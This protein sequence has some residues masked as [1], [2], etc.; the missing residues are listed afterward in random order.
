MGTGAGTR[1]G[2]VRG[3]INVSKKSVGEF[4][5]PRRH[6]YNDGR[7]PPKVQ[8]AP[9]TVVGPS[10]ECSN[11]RSRL[12]SPSILHSRLAR[13]GGG[14]GNHYPPTTFLLSSIHTGQKER[15][16]EAGNRLVSIKSSPHHPHIQNGNCVSNF[17]FHLGDSLGLLYR[18]RRRI[19]SRA[20]IL[21]VP[22]ISRLPSKGKNL[23]L[24]VSSL[25]SGFGSVGVFPGHKTHQTAFARSPDSHIQLP[26][27]FCN[28]RTLTRGAPC[29]HGCG[30]GFT[31]ASGVQDKLGEVQSG[32]FPADRISGSLLGLKK[33]RI[34]HSPRQT[35]INQDALSGDVSEKLDDQEGARESDGAD[36]LRI[37]LHYPG[38]ASSPPRDDVDEPPL[39]PLHQ[40]RLYSSGWGSQEVA[41]DLDGPV[42][43]ESARSDACSSAVTHLDDRRII[44]GLVWNP[45]TTEG[46]GG[47]AGECV[48]LFHEL[49]GA[50]GDPAGSC[51]ISVPPSGQDGPTVVRQ[52]NGSGL[53][54]PSG[55]GE[56]SAPTLPDVGDTDF[57]QGRINHLTSRTPTGSPECPSGPRVA[58]SSD[59]Y[60]MV[61]RQADVRMD[62]QSG[63]SVRSGP[64][65]NEGKRPSGS[66]CFSLPGQLGSG[67]QR[68]Q[69]RLEPLGMHLPD[70]PNK[71]PS[72]GCTVSTGLS[73]NRD[74]RGSVMAIEGVVSPS[75]RSLQGVSPSPPAELPITPDDGERLG[76]SRQPL[77]LETSRLAALRAPWI[78]EGLSADSVEIVTNAHKASTRRNYQATWSKFLD[79]LRS[80]NIPHSEV[81]VYVVMNFLSHQFTHFGRA[82]RTVASYKCALA[83]P[84]WTTFGIP[85]SDSSLDLFMRGVFNLAPPRP[86][87]MPSWSLDTLLAFLIS[88][89]FEPLHTKS[90]LLVTQKTLCLLLLA[91]GRRIDEVAHLSKYHVFQR[92]G[93]AVSIHWLSG[94]TPK[95]FTRLFQPE[96]P[97]FER[98]APGADSDLLLCPVR[99][100]NTYLGRVGGG[101]RFSRKAPLWA[102]NGKALTN[103]FK[104]TLFQA[105]HQAGFSEVV[106][107]GP[108][109]MRKLAASYSAKMV[110]NSPTGVRKLRDR[111]G[112]ASMSVLKRTY[113]NDVPDLSFRVVLPA[114]TY[115]PNRI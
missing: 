97:S 40:G 31:S 1:K 56:T 13:D 61:S 99:A 15:K 82:Y 66:V 6:Q 109:Q 87:D 37:K 43:P 26:G 80:N 102:H 70:A 95:H 62:Q 25:R 115:V 20:N 8:K 45:T 65:C 60:R 27:R 51:G 58:L 84:L 17:P 76:S 67:I 5:G 89:N 53:S 106:S 114:G 28:L 30:S 100:F 92:D 10:P 2:A 44:G 75:S 73:G 42:F 39:S 23:C 79:F 72:G 57:L 68:L 22:Q 74:S 113:I 36:E 96:F 112:C 34:V 54:A 41:G 110:G 21:G 104:T 69:P 12:M 81:T 59:P 49:E 29:S 46:H 50:Q 4:E 103:L 64:F 55:V 86:A 11:Q 35:D 108:H 63:S 90:L 105:R 94:Y 18:H 48:P 101:P 98:M 52:H 111:M 9:S 16:T 93:E 3:S 107:T 24:P 7:V 47:L 77:L 88:D 91:S 85:L 33:L 32:S 78:R 14:K 71:L 38:E 19:F 83:H